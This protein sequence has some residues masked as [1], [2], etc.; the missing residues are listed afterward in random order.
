MNPEVRS[1]A[2]DG[3]NP[4]AR[5]G[6]A[7]NSEAMNTLGEWRKSA[8]ED[9]PHADDDIGCRSNVAAIDALDDFLVRLE[10][11]SARYQVRACNSANR[12]VSV[13][14]T[15]PE[16][17]GE[18]RRRSVAIGEMLRAWQTEDESKEQIPLGEIER[19]SLRRVP[20]ASA[21]P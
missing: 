16:T 9:L 14:I 5:Q 19:V 7:K 15:L 17:H 21:G 3:P 4:R 8:S 12:A 13:T 10:A 20:E 2:P 11:I 18:S 6:S 1:T